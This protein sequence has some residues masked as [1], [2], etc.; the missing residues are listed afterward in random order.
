MMKKFLSAM[1]VIAMCLPVS[2]YAAEE[3][4]DIT[5]VVEGVIAAPEL[6]YAPSG[7]A[8]DYYISGTVGCTYVVSCADEVV[9]YAW[10]CP[11][12]VIGYCSVDKQSLVRWLNTI[13]DTRTVGVQGIKSGM[14]TKYC[15]AACCASIINYYKG[16]NLGYED[17]VALIPG[18]GA[19]GWEQMSYV[20]NDKYG[21]N[22]GEVHRSLK[23]T[24]MWSIFGAGHPIHVG[25]MQARVGSS[26][27]SGHSILLTGVALGSSYNVLYIY[28]PSTGANMVFGMHDSRNTDT[29]TK[30]LIL[31]EPDKFGNVDQQWCFKWEDSRWRYAS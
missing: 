20:Y 3:Y 2:A 29:G 28:E 8:K 9:G 23:T 31:R 5:G 14:N 24:E 12:G 15:W 18:V 22:I 10:L 19:G 17:I 13:Y 4:P 6:F 1:L 11:D 27:W 25:G 7:N 16:T 21:L 30:L 26:D